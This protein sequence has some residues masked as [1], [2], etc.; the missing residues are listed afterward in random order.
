MNKSRAAD[1]LFWVT[2]FMAILP[3]IILCFF[4][5]PGK[6][7]Y[8][9]ENDFK[10]FDFWGGQAALYGY[11]NG[12]FFVNALEIACVKMNF[13]SDLYFLL[14][15]L[16]FAATYT[17]TFL[18]LGT[19]NKLLLNNQLSINQLLQASFIFLLLNIYLL[20]DI[21]SNFYWFSG[22]IVYQTPVILLFILGILLL[23]R[24]CDASK[25]KILSDIFI[26]LLIILLIG[27]N[28]TIAVATIVLLFFVSVTSIRFQSAG[29]K[30][31]I[32]YFLVAFLSGIIVLF[33]AGIL[34]RQ[35]MMHS[36]TRY[37]TV[38]AIIVFRTG[39]VFYNIFKEP[40]FWLSSFICLIAGSRFE[41]GLFAKRALLFFTS[42]KKILYSLLLLPL[43]IALILTPLLML[44]KGSFP[45]R[46]LNNIILIAVICLLMLAFVSGHIIFRDQFNAVA[47]KIGSLYRITIT[48][49]AMLLSVTYMGAWKSVLSGY[50]YHAILIERDNQ[51]LQAKNNN[52]KTITILSYN[53]ALKQKMKESFPGRGFQSVSELLMQPPITIPFFNEAEERRQT[54]YQLHYEIERII[55]QPDKP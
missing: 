45:E 8:F 10:H 5:H 46:A 55:I 37:I 18:L 49:A 30:T 26:A 50:F 6:E 40:L 36:N 48:G 39:L 14:P 12:R 19:I 11:W 13:I 32:F 7:D 3:F 44:A 54:Y 47:E 42:P 28:E 2:A 25:T 21:A 22:A 35:K 17:T 1:I 4:S 20:A 38:L 51:F 52:Q 23:K 53:A 31:I 29:K 34:N 41:M 27:C 43:L 9:F 33:T 16:L 15:L 24:F